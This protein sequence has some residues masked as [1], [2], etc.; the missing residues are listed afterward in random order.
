VSLKKIGDSQSHHHDSKSLAGKTRGPAERAPSRANEDKF[1]KAPE[2]EL[3]MMFYMHGQ[4][5]DVG[6]VAA[7]SLA[8]IA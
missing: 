1:V 2:K 4:Y 8:N 3:T 7:E 6:N 5:D